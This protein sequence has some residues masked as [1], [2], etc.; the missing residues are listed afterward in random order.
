MLNKREQKAREFTVSGPRAPSETRASF[1]E[2]TAG[3]L[4]QPAAAQGRLLASELVTAVVLQHGAPSPAAITVRVSPLRREGV[5]V[6]VTIP[7]RVGQRSV[8]AFRLVAG[9]RAQILDAMATRWGLVHDVGEPYV[10]F[11]LGL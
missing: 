2:V 9:Y 5:R 3:W 7:R 6:E 11:E 4:P 10:W 1:D 8:S